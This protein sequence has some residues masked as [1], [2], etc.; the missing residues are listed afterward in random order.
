MLT[1]FGKFCR[2]LRIDTGELLKEMA[3]KLGVTSSYLSAVENG[4]RNIPKSW[5]SI[6]IKEYSLNTDHQRELLRAVEESR[7]STKVD[8]KGYGNDD[9]TLIMAFARELKDLDEDNKMKIREIL[10]NHKKGGHQ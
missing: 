1:L 4:K 8:M 7:I 3:D 6:L 2:K 9:K 5:P 10:S